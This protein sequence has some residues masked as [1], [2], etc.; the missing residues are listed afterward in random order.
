MQ[1]IRAKGSVQPRVPACKLSVA[2]SAQIQQDT[3]DKVPH[4]MQVSAPHLAVLAA[5]EVRQIQIHA[6][7]SCRDHISNSVLTDFS[8]VEEF[9][10]LKAVWQETSTHISCFVSILSSYNPT[11]LSASG[12]MV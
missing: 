2:W 7:E 9:E 6:S 3:L 4:R 5:G 1:L 11:L 12:V 10:E 8:A